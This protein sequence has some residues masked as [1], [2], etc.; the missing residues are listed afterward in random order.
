M[1]FHVCQFVPTDSVLSLDTHHL[2]QVNALLIHT[3]G[4]G[5]VEVCT[6]TAVSLKKKPVQLQSV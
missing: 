3:V 6:D 4:S 5:F 1:E 2:S